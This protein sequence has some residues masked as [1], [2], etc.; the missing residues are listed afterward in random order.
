MGKIKKTYEETYSTIPVDDRHE[1]VLFRFITCPVCGCAC[2]AALQNRDEEDNH[3]F[4]Y[5]GCSHI[6]P[7]RDLGTEH[8]Y[9]VDGIIEREIYKTRWEIC[10]G[11]EP[12]TVAR[13]NYELGI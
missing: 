9:S 13:F 12:Q 8:V 10:W 11:V 5:D 3:F 4:S 6:R 7:I 1:R 2:G